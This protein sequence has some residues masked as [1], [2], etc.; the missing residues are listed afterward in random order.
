MTVIE[1]CFAG[2]LVLGT[3]WR[4]VVLTKYL[5]TTADWPE[6]GS[7]GSSLQPREKFTA[8]R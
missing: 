3:L 1:S 2:G 6:T 4:R 5:Y 7:S 8:Y